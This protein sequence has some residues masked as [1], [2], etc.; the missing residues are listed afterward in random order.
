MV[1]VW[2]LKILEQVLQSSP[3]ARGCPWDQSHGGCSG[4]RQQ[5]GFLR[6]LLKHPHPAG[7]PDGTPPMGPCPAS[8]R[9]PQSGVSDPVDAPGRS[10]RRL[11]RGEPRGQVLSVWG[12]WALEAG[13]VCAHPPRRF[14]RDELLR[15]Q[16]FPSRA[17]GA[18]FPVIIQFVS[19][20]ES[21]VSLD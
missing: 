15:T 17:S 1:P 11:R 18:G 19:I 14:S 7:T 4:C 8:R 16:G 21:L 13:G 2:L 10:V 20:S 6:A 5:A 3:Q 12:P 9:R